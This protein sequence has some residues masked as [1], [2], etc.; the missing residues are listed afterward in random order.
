VSGSGAD[1]V[2]DAARLGLEALVTGETREHVMGDATEL[3]VQVIAAGHY[4]TETFGVRRL[5][6]LLED[7]FGVEHLWIDAPNPV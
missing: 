5:G 1:H 7:R 2:Y 4:A 6:T 3:G